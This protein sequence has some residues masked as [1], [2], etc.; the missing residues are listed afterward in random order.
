MTDTLPPMNGCPKSGATRRTRAIFGFLKDD[1]DVF[2]RIIRFAVTSKYAC[3]WLSV[4]SRVRDRSCYLLAKLM[5]SSARVLVFNCGL[6]P[7]FWSL[8]TGVVMYVQH[9]Y[10]LT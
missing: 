4:T 2:H 1:L 8:I 5:W 9:H 10:S 6:V 7:V 3:S